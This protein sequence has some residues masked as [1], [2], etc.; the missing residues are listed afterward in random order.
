MWLTLHFYWGALTS[1]LLLSLSEFKWMMIFDTEDIIRMEISC[2]R[3]KGLSQRC[4]GHTF[5][6]PRSQIIIPYFLPENTFPE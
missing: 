4:T 1:V 2:F 5:T 6:L 3:A